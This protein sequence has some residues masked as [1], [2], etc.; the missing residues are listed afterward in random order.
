M[1]KLLPLIFLFSY[2]A[3]YSQG[4]SK[5]QKAF[6]VG[7]DI[8]F[9][10]N[11][12]YNVGFGGSGKAEVPIIGN[13]SL[14]ATAGFT[15]FYYKSSFL[16]NTKTQAPSGFLP[17]KAGAKYYISEGFY[18]EGELGTAIETNYSKNKLFAFSF[19]PGFIIP[20][21]KHTGIDV[22]LRYENWG[23]GRVRQT[24]IRV[25]YRLGW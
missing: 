10:T 21:G 16:G 1:K 17:L 12:I 22:G 24:G 7:L 5:P 6:G 3:A 19:S 2:I 14:T 11:S 15:S 13:V 18:L 9:P 8:A 20:T 25:A 23:S 4:Q